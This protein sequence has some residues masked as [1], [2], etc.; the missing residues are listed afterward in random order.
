MNRTSRNR[1]V[2]IAVFSALLAA[3]VTVQAAAQ[4]SPAPTT[5]DGCTEITSARTQADV[6]KIYDRHAATVSAQRTAA[7]QVASTRRAQAR[8]AI[9][10]WEKAQQTK[11]QELGKA[12]ARLANLVN[13]FVTDS[14]PWLKA[15][16]D[17]AKKELDELTSTN[18]AQATA[19]VAD[20]SKRYVAAYAAEKETR[21]FIEKLTHDEEVAH[22][23]YD[24][25]EAESKRAD[26]ESSRVWTK[27]W[28]LERC[29][30]TRLAQFN[31]KDAAAIASVE[32][33]ATKHQRDIAELEKL[34][35][36]A[37]SICPPAAAA[38]AGVEKSASNLEAA[39]RKLAA[40]AKAQES[41]QPV[42]APINPDVANAAR[43]IS[44]LSKH[45]AEAALGACEASKA[46]L[47]A[48]HD[49]SA[50]ASLGEALRY[51]STAEADVTMAANFLN[52]IRAAH[53]AAAPPGSPAAPAAPAAAAGG[54]TAQLDAL[55]ARS[56]AELGAAAAVKSMLSLQTFAQS[57]TTAENAAK[58]SAA[59]V[60]RVVDAAKDAGLPEM[61]FRTLWSQRFLELATRHEAA[62]KGVSC[63][64]ALLA[65]LERAA[66]GMAATHKALKDAEAAVASAQ[67]KSGA[68]TNP[69][70]EIEAIFN[71]ARSDADIVAVEAVTAIGCAAAAQTAMAAPPAAAPPPAAAAPPATPPVAPPPAAGP[72]GEMEKDFG[73]RN[74]DFSGKWV[75][76]HDQFWTFTIT[77]GKGSR[78]PIAAQSVH[79]GSANFDNKWSGTCIRTE[80]NKAVCEGRGTYQDDLREMAFTVKVVMY[81]HDGVTLNYDAKY[82]STNLVRMK[83]PG[84]QP[85]PGGIST[86]IGAKQSLKKG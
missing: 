68:A 8:T 59:E 43:A 42:T 37:P 85:S 11:Q 10:Q 65:K 45:A 38:I 7:D 36:Q 61:W 21:A 33:A 40:D 77:K 48:P 29:R 2:G 73:D 41:R 49:P 70:A 55:R 34:A 32:A 20:L 35:R 75:D 57:V 1:I 23:A 19:R 39:L 58:A 51:R 67:A 44:S 28:D 12:Q 16:L 79:R 86:Q 53:A 69:R 31:P 56:A 13:Q 26:E 81:V 25:A 27:S 60:K 3:M 6:E 83:V 62:L 50:V 46:I 52:V 64:F 80:V 78:F 66:Q 47:A 15:E 30:V 18:K 82:T 76:H 84:M 22:R 14:V 54:L 9:F 17:K 74:A 72:S 71:A 4:T 63:A 5:P 24:Q